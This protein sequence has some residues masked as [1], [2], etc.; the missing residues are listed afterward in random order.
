MLYI[1]QEIDALSE[2]EEIEARDKAIEAGL[3][4]C[5]CFDTA[6]AAGDTE[7]GEDSNGD[8][9]NLAARYDLIALFLWY[10][11][12]RAFLSFAEQLRTSDPKRSAEIRSKINL[13][14]DATHKMV[15]SSLSSVLT[16]PVPTPQTRRG[17]RVAAPKRHSRNRDHDWRVAAARQS[18]PIA[19]LTYYTMNSKYGLYAEVPAS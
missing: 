17:A 18:R 12:G 8:T 14:V 7:L 10:I 2:D 11:T 3:K 15:R 19:Q 6:F 16:T 4:M 13:V 9:T 5:N 1:H